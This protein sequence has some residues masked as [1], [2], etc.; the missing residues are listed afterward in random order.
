MN[1][2][3]IVLNMTPY[4]FGYFVVITENIVALFT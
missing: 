4:F 3:Y 2:F 1:D